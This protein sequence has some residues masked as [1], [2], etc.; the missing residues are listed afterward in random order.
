MAPSTSALIIILPKSSNT[1]YLKTGAGKNKSL[2]CLLEMKKFF[3]LLAEFNSYK[4]L[5]Y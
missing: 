3:P 2:I 4:K 1:C 5:Y